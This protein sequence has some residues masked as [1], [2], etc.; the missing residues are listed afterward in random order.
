[1]KNI[2]ARLKDIFF[3]KVIEEKIEEYTIENIPQEIIDL[4]ASPLEETK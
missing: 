3:N 1:M 4:L 2:L